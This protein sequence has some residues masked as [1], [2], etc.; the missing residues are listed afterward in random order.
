MVV[1]LT[2]VTL[3]QDM[4][5]YPV[6]LKRFVIAALCFFSKATHVD[7]PLLLGLLYFFIFSYLFEKSLSEELFFYRIQLN[8]GRTN[9]INFGQ[10]VFWKELMP[11]Q[12][13]R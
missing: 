1:A 9:T 7:M 13:E 10:Q 2:R 4:R 6:C 5:W 12:V 3:C 8:D 11:A